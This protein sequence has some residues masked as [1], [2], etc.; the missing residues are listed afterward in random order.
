VTPAGI[1]STVAG[2]GSATCSIFGGNFWGDGG[3]ATDAGFYNP[4]SL[5]VSPD[6]AVYVGD[7]LNARIRRFRIDGNI[8]TL[9]GG[10]FVTSCPGGRDCAATQYNLGRPDVLA[11]GVRGDLYSTDNATVARLSSALEPQRI[12]VSNITVPSSDGL[13]VYVFDMQGRHLKTVDA[14][15]NVDI[16]VFEYD[17]GRLK[18]LK[19]R[20]NNTTTIWRDAQGNPSAIE[21]PYH[22]RTV[23]G[24][25]S[26][27]YLHI[28]TNPKGET[29]QLLYK[30]TVPGD[31]TGGL[32]S[33]LIDARNGTHEYEYDADGNGFLTKDTTPDGSWVTLDR[34]G[35]LAPTGVTSK[36]ARGRTKLYSTSRSSLGDSETRTTQDRAGLITTEKR[37]GDYSGSATFP[38]GTTV[39]MV[40]AAMRRGCV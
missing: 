15:A 12:G 31:H 29:V 28:V 20:D 17:A 30:A 1:I 35:A 2:S 40:E 13:E 37:N 22:Q 23:L 10:A 27:G 4:K 16:A 7:Y 26:D 34:G 33:R 18:S 38:D 39:T 19:D 14:L 36:D 5:A 25:D 8:S 24:L 9:A 32:L 6:G 21:G 3:L 11:L